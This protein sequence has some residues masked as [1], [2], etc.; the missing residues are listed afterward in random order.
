MCLSTKTIHLELVG[1]LTTSSFLRALARLV[2]RRGK[3]NEI[4][5]DRGTNLCGV[6]NELQN[7]L[8]KAKFDWECVVNNLAQQ[9]IQSKFIPP[10]APHFGGIREA[11][12]KSAKRHLRCIIGPRKLTYEEF[13]TLLTDVERI[14]NCRPLVPFTRDIDD[15]DVL[16]PG[17]LLIGRSLTSIPEPSNSYANVNALTHWT[18]VKTLRDKFWCHWSREYL[19][20]LQHRTK[21]IRPSHILQIGDLVAIIDP[22]LLKANGKWPLGRVVEIHQGQD[23]LV[24]VITIRTASGTYTRPIFELVLIAPAMEGI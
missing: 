24:R 2:N 23:Q 21:W 18:L 12:V 6:K 9:G 17:H 7:L 14:L 15:L 10:C 1:N 16:T 19:N 3:P 8:K 11:G 13:S 4:S 20:T 22:S 5:N